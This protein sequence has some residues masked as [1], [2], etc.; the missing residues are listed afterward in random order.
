MEILI[1]LSAKNKPSFVNESCKLPT[2]DSTLFILWAHCNDMVLP[3]IL[4]SLS[5]EITESVHYSL[6]VADPW[7]TFEQKYGQ[8]DGT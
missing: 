6:I 8:A 3:W 4:N 5:K 2:K 1:S 7:K